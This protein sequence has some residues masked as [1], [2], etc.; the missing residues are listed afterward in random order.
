M[1]I[2]WGLVTFLIGLLYGLLKPGWQNKGAM[3]REGLFIG[4]VVAVVV[5]LIGAAT[6]YPALGLVDAVG[7]IITALIL[8][9]LF[10]VGVWLGDLLTSGRHQTRYN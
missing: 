3:F 4:I 8:S 9:L 6:G 1:A 5:A 2:P 7:I 10:I